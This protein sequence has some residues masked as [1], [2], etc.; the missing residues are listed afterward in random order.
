M[1]SLVRVTEPPGRP[2]RPGGYPQVL[3]AATQEGAGGGRRSLLLGQVEGAGRQQVEV[4]HARRARLAT[5]CTLALAP[6][7]APAWAALT[8]PD[9]LAL[10]SRFLEGRRFSILRSNCQ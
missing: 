7:A 9:R 4:L 6:L 1:L 8:R 5:R 3:E 2:C 10:A